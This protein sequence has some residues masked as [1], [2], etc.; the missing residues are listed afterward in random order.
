M[1][2]KGKKVNIMNFLKVY[3]LNAVLGFG[4]GVTLVLISLTF[5]SQL[6]FGSKLPDNPQ[7]ALSNEESA[8]LKRAGQGDVTVQEKDQNKSLL[9]QGEALNSSRFTVL[10]VGTD[11]RPGENYVGNTD[12]LLVTSIDTVNHRM[13][14]LSIPRDTQVNLSS[15]GIQK[16][17]AIARLQ[18]GLPSTQKYIEQLIGF[19]IDGY[20][21]TNFNGFKTIVDSLGG[22]T[23]D[24]EKNMRYDTGDGQ[25]RYIDLNKG[26]QRLNG[27]QALQYARFRNDELADISR[28]ARQQA[29]L[30]AI[31]AEATELKNLPK[32]PLV[33]SK[34]YQAVQT[35][36]NIGQ[37][38]ALANTFNKKDTFQTVSQTLPGNF[39][40]EQGISYWKV[41]S[42]FAKKVVSQLYLEGKTTPVLT[43]R[44]NDSAQA[45]VTSTLNQRKKSES[46]ESKTQE[47]I[48]NKAE[49]KADD[50]VKNKAENSLEDGEAPKKQPVKKESIK[51]EQV[52]PNVKENTDSE[53]QF[54]VVK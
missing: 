12:S 46:L 36:L 48:D 13:S 50:T 49:D 53:I 6:H 19:K 23:V 10:L 14:F 52:K 5:L 35:D 1:L 32:L 25:D 45:V 42:D 9:T 31:F 21:M 39:V 18:K 44:T 8:S 3:G 7:S 41:N 26:T 30:K 22:I 54:E 33:I 24:V 34:V 29:I 16:I 2:K 4:L 27:S 51:Q 17:N 43:Q 28:T 38:W 20:V 40:T 11:N 15:V 47:T 37:L